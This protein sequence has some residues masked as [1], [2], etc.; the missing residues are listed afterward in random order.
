MAMV[1]MKE[2]SK[3]KVMM[4]VVTKRENKVEE[5]KELGEIT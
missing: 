4:V 2:K 3:E 5:R 1:V